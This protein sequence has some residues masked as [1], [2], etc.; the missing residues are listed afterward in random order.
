MSPLS[1]PVQPVFR[2]LLSNAI[3]FSNSGGTITVKITVDTEIIRVAV[4]DNGVGMTSEQI[5]RLFA[6]F[7]QQSTP[8]TDNE[9]G[10]GLGF[11]LINDFVKMNNGKVNVESE[12]H[13]GSTFTVTIPRAQT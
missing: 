9:K 3:K 4:A 7:I 2:N 12:L 5:D 8:G 1:M 11:G 6:Q 10:T 13:K